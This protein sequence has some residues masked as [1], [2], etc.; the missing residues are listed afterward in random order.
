MLTKR[1]ANPQFASRKSFAKSAKAFAEDYAS[2]LCK[3]P[4]A[5]KPMLVGLQSR[6]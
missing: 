3:N 2:R 6:C 5:P 1:G 4:G